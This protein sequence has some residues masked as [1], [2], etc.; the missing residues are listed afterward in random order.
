MTTTIANQN[1]VKFNRG[2]DTSKTSA[3]KPIASQ[4]VE[5][6][7]QNNG[8]RRVSFLSALLRAFSAVAV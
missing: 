2:I 5:A 8:K 3:I 4:Q 6:A 7:T 1:Q